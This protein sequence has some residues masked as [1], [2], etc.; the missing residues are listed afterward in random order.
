MNESAKKLQFHENA[1]SENT[2]PSEKA[3]PYNKGHFENLCYIWT[4]TCWTY[5]LFH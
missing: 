1:S 4:F 5:P 3:S 2:M